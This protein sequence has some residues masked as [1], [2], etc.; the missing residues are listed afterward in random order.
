MSKTPF[1]YRYDVRF[2]PRR[3]V[4][5]PMKSLTGR[6]S[7]ERIFRH[8]LAQT[9][10]V[11][12]GAAGMASITSTLASATGLPAVPTY[13][14]ITRGETA[15]A[16]K[17]ANATPQVKADIT[18]L[19]KQ[20]PKL[21]SADALMKDYR[22]LGIVL[23]AFQMKD[24]LAYPGLV[25]K[26]ITEDPTSATSTAKKIGNPT[27]L[28]F[29]QAMGQYKTNP[30][31]SASNLT[32]ITNAYVLNSYEADQGQKVPGMQDALAFKR[33]AAQVTSIAQ[34]MS[35]TSLLKVA[36]AETGLDWSTFGVMQYDQQVK[37]L[38]Q[39]TKLADFQNG[40][41]VDKMAEQYLLT[42]GQ[43]PSAWSDA[44]TTNSNSVVS[45]LSSA[46][47]SDPIL[48]VLNGNSSSSSGSSPL[49][50]LFA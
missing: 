23:G 7:G 32:A 39:T 40:A 31:G 20:A 25:R 21:T 26:L 27:Y 46:T 18:Y 42:A 41:K 50:S 14:A 12:D 10:P 49:L 28:R 48:S 15:L 8:N 34:L 37:V 2:L 3:R 13:L 6:L 38:T 44:P 45:L 35:N 36:V 11:P 24:Q 19:T 4:H 43:N 33:Q 1:A 47:T 5:H 29:A 30:L 22:A 16:A 9:A 17:Y